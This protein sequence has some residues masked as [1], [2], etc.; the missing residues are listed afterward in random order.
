MN[1]EELINKYFEG[2]TTCE[3]ERELRHF[4]TTDIVPEHLETYRSLF[5][6]FDA[7]I[8]QQAK[9]PGVNNKNSKHFV[10]KY[11]LYSLSAIAASILLLFGITGIYHHTATPDNYVVIDGKQYTD[12][13]IVKEQA[14]AAF[15]DVSLSEE[16]V[17]ETL[18]AD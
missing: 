7:E 1:I 10:R 18:F 17:F 16:D 5:A 15:K 2:E 13:S 6:F 11:V 12:A 8:K 4:F 14:M 9:V 3:E